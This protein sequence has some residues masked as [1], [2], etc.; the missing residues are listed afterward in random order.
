MLKLGAVV[1]PYGVKNRLGDD[2]VK[3]DT[4]VLVRFKFTALP[5]KS[6]KNSQVHVHKLKASLFPD[7][8]F[9]KFDF[10]LQNKLSH[11]SNFSRIHLSPMKKI[12]LNRTAALLNKSLNDANDS[13]YL[14]ALHIINSKIL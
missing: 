10:Y 12:N 6:A 11:T 1:F 3:E 13:R 2:L 8:Y 4:R 9:N 5:W 7:A 14:M